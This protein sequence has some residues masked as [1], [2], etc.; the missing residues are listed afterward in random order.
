MT[1]FRVDIIYDSIGLYV[2]GKDNFIDR[3]TL[4][5]S[6]QSQNLR[7]TTFYDN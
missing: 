3:Y 1:F 7:I 5:K 6:V 2:Y 4:F